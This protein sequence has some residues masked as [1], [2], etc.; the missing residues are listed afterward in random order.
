MAKPI[1][2]DSLAD[3]KLLNVE[4]VAELVGISIRQVYALES[5][6]ILPR[7]IRI[8]G[9]CVRWQRGVIEQWIEGGCQPWKRRGKGN[10]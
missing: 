5:H 6:G 4:A 9:G 8:T 2:L 10:G 1:N 7:A 3:K